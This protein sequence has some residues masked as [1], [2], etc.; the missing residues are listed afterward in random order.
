MK[1]GIGITSVNRPEHLNLC[2]KMI[3]QFTSDANIHVNID[4]EKKGIAQAKNNCLEKLF[5]EH[6]C[7][8]VFLFDDDCFPIVNDWNLPFVNSTYKHLSYLNQRHKPFFNDGE[9]SYYHDCGGVM[10]YLTK[11]VFNKVGYFNNKYNGYGFEHSGYS[12]RVARAGLIPH[13]FIGLNCANKLFHAF[14]Y[15]GEKQYG[16]KHVGSLNTEE[17]KQH[18]KDNR[19]VY[20]FENSISPIYQGK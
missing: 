5:V 17:M 4:I 18:I 19:E 7:S 20:N 16:I 14:D 1:L 2:L 9:A 13:A 8:H 6:D 3:N 11:D 10:I 15:D 12:K